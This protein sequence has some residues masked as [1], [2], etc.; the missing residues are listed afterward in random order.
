VR[1]KGQNNSPAAGAARSPHATRWPI[2]SNSEGEAELGPEPDADDD[3]AEP[4][5]EP[6]PEPDPEPESDPEPEPEPEPDGL[7]PSTVASMRRATLHCSQ[8]LND[9]GWLFRH[10]W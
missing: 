5:P 4:E 6:E 3:D 8:R 10:A 1:V 7:A 9:D 2:P